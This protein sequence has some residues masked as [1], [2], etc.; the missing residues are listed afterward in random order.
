MN[1]LYYI[2]RIWI[3]LLAKPVSDVEKKIIEIYGTIEN[4]WFETE[5]SSGNLYFEEEMLNKRIH[6]NSLKKKAI[7][8]YDKCKSLYINIVLQKRLCANF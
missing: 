5:K 3:T 8:I 4:A 2:I 6:D 1:D 7:N